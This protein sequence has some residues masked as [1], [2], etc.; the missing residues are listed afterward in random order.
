MK[1]L[2]VLYD[3][4]CSM[5]CRARRWLERQPQYVPLKF[6]GAATRHAE[7]QFPE[8]DPKETL[9]QL[10]VVSDD[11]S[12]YHGAKAWV[13][14]LWALRQYRGWSLTLGSDAMLPSAQRFVAWISRNR[15]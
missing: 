5:C 9:E 10:T 3:S 6:V 4:A 1:S 13:M 15:K 8:L 2:T 12:V 7:E 11:G 14:C